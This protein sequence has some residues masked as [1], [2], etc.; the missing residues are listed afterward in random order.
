[1]IRKRL[2]G[3][4]TVRD[5]WA[6]Q[7]FGYG[8]YLPLGRPE[9]LVENLDR[10]GADEVLLQCIDRGTRGPDLDLLAR[11]SALGLAT[12]LIYAGGIRDAADATAVVAAAADRV[13]IDALL[14]DDLSHVPR[15]AE[16][17]GSQAVIAALPLSRVDGALKW[18]DHRDGSE[19]PLDPAVIQLLADCVISEALVIDWRHEGTPGSFDATLLDGVAPDHVP[20]IAFGGLSA[21]EDLADVLGRPHVA[22]AAIGNFLSYEEHA[23]QRYKAALAALPLRPAAYHRTQYA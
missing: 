19:R 7:S 2:I 13:V 6:V 18:L 9:V 4:V 8:R 11:I 23:V 10:W 17:L 21:P 3:V 5:G 12:P 15:I 20:L 16:Q 14:H 22:A 1:M